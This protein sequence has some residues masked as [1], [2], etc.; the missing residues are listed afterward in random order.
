[1]T[2]VLLAAQSVTGAVIGAAIAFTGF[3]LGAAVSQ[4]TTKKE[5]GD[6]P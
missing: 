3:L 1:M 6:R 5:K 2:A 4:A